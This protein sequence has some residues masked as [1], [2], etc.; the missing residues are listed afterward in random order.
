MKARHTPVLCL[1][2]AS[3]A[4]LAFKPSANPTGPA[5]PTTYRPRKAACTKVSKADKNRLLSAVVIG[6]FPPPPT[7]NSRKCRATSRPASAFPIFP[8]VQTCPVPDSARPPAAKHREANGMSAVTQTSPAPIRSAIQSSAASGVSFTTTI[9]TF[10][11]PGGR[12]GRDPF[13]TTNTANPSRVATRNASPR[14]GQAS[15]S[16]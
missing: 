10:G 14:T 16:M 13:E 4:S 3:L 7:P 1:F 9:V 2:F 11:N 8:S 12:I 6:A 5:P 15:A